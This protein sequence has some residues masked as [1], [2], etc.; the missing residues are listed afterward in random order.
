MDQIKIFYE[1]IDEESPKSLQKTCNKW[2]EKMS[3][4]IVVKNILQ[5]FNEDMDLVITIHYIQKPLTL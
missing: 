1:C 4:S 3:E 5:S 2:L